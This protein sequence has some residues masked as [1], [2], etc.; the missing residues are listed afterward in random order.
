[1]SGETPEWA[2]WLILGLLVFLMLLSRLKR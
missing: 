2:L 1:M